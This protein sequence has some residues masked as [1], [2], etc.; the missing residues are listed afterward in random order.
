MP[1]WVGWACFFDMG[2]RRGLELIGLAFILLVVT[3]PGAM[4]YLDPGTG[5]AVWQFLAASFLGL[6]F[7]LK[8]FWRRITA[9]FRRVLHHEGVD[10]AE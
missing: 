5:A 3:A 10:D 4:A 6:L 9:F 2:V 8:V 1:I 7:A